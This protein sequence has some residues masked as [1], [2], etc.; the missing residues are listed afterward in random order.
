MKNED[1]PVTVEQIGAALVALGAYDGNNTPAEHAE[2]ATQFGRSEIYRLRLLN[3]LLGSVQ[4]QAKLADE[5]EGD[6]EDLFAAWF[7]QLKAADA[8]DDPVKQMAFLGWQVRRAGIPLH[9]IA[10]APGAGPIVVAAAHAAEAL[11][12]LLGVI[13]A[14][15]EANATGD[16][17]TVVAQVGVLKAAR[18]LLVAALDNADIM[19]DTVKS[20]DS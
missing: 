20:A 2:N 16:V 8:W 9:W 14:V 18:E 17:E 6:G 13:G 1:I 3:T 5:V 11:H 10:K 7:E 12:V 15:D 19:L 4:A